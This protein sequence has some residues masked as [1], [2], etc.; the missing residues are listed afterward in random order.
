[1]KEAEEERQQAQNVHPRERKHRSFWG[2]DLVSKK[3]LRSIG[4]INSLGGGNISRDKEPRV[5]DCVNFMAGP[6]Q[7][8]KVNKN[9]AI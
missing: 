6:K 2:R 3:H 5:C 7:W 9:A 4:P 1:M 8:K